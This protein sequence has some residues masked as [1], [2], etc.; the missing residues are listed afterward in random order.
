ML[1]ITE[2]NYIKLLYDK[3]QKSVDYIKNL[4]ENNEWDS[5]EYAV[6]DKENLIKQIVQFEKV[7]IEKIKL[8]SELMKIRNNLVKLEKE[9]IALVKKMQEDLKKEISSTIKAKKVLNTYEP[10]S[11]MSLSTIDISDVDE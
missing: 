4:M 8:N 5:V 7:H 3:L 10:D 1:S 6:S 11:S 2:Y 9:N